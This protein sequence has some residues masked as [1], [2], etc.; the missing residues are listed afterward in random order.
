MISTT[1]IN[2]ARKT[3]AGQKDLAG[4]P[5]FAHVERV[6]NRVMML[7]AKVSVPPIESAVQEVRIFTDRCV[8]AAYLHDVLEDSDQ[9]TEA[10]AIIFESCG[11]Q[12]LDAVELLTRNAGESYEDYMLRLVHS[13]DLTAKLVK[14]ADLEDHLSLD[15]VG[16]IEGNLNPDRRRKYLNAHLRL[17][18]N[19]SHPFSDTTLHRQFELQSYAL[20]HL[21]SVYNLVPKEP[22]QPCPEK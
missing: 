7:I 1:A 2:L 10:R 21:S 16:A 22:V 11:Q 18:A 14:L 8:V 6:A 4:Q 20:E 9:P 19:L 5:Y 12:V 17:L 3:H 15:H 13:S